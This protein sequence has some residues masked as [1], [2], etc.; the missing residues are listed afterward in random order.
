M[1][2]NNKILDKKIIQLTSINKIRKI[3]YVED[4]SASY[5]SSFFEY[6]I[7]DII[8]LKLKNL[9]YN[10]REYDDIVR[11]LGKVYYI[12][13]RMFL[14]PELVRSELKKEQ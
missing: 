12:H 13:S 7:G 4:G 2:N 14:F 8:K 5:S 3:I 11:V 10:L 1:F 6:S 9:I